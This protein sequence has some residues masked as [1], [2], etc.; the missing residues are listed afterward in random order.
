[1]ACKFFIN[2]IGRLTDKY[3]KLIA[4][5]QKQEAESSMCLLEGCADWW[6]TVS[7]IVTKINVFF[8]DTQGQKGDP[9]L[10]PRQ[11]PKGQKV[12]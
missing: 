2:A 4:L 7:K 9:G 12:W 1:M 8:F 10:S 11:A 3:S 6:I 5:F